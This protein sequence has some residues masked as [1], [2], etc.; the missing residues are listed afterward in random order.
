MMRSATPDLD[1]PRGASMRVHSPREA[2]DHLE[3]L[4]EETGDLRRKLGLP[5][6]GKRLLETKLDTFNLC[7]LQCK[8]CGVHLIRDVIHP[9]P[10]S[11][12]MLH[13]VA[14]Q[15]FPYCGDLCFGSLAEPLMS[16]V[17]DEAMDLGK[18][19]GVPYLQMVTNALLLDERWAQKVIDIQLD[20]ISVSAD[21]ASQETY[22]RIRNGD[23]G[24]VARNTERLRDLKTQLGSVLPQI[25]F[26]FVLMRTTLHEMPAMV[27]FAHGM[28]AEAVDFS[29]PVLAGPLDMEDELPTRDRALLD[30]MLAMARS[31]MEDLGLPTER[32]PV[33][34][35]PRDPGSS[36]ENSVLEPNPDG[37][38]VCL[39]PWSFMVIGPTGDV[40]PCCAPFMLGAPPMG[41][42]G[43]NTFA[44]ILTGPR[45]DDVRRSL[46]TARL[47][48]ECARCKAFDLVSTCYLDESHYL[49]L[50][51]RL[52]RAGT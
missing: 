52:R 10:M 16:P 12:G 26:N 48:D 42:L 47:H 14:A 51:P 15:V 43:E 22:T 40:W 28:G 35:P 49:G 24:K 2:K 25:R 23:L 44:Q 45:Y 21:A 9:M 1:V 6:I 32:L 29:L 39:A 20:R 3:K 4:V 37:S 27:D 41:N 30:E 13:D 11:I 17:I 8:Q 5:D 46:I 31:R 50:G 19:A 33:I 7:N 36:A 38:P 34:P 18:A